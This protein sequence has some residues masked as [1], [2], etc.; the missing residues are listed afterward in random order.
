MQIL[1][2]LG[3]IMDVTSFVKDFSEFSSSDSP[4]HLGIMIVGFVKA[5]KED[6]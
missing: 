1:D 6:I 3:L 4:F 2:L 5:K